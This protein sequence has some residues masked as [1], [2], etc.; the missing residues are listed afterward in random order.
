MKPPASISHEVAA[1]GFDGIVNLDEANEPAAHITAESTQS[2]TPTTVA[3]PSGWSRISDPQEADPHAARQH[4]ARQA[5]RAQPVAGA[6]TQSG[7]EAIR[8]DASPVGTSF[9]A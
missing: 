6:T 1:N 2:P 8:S 3:F 9:S 4:G 7:T 5:A